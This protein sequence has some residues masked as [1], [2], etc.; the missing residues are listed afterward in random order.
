VSTR[1][2]AAP[3]KKYAAPLSILLLTNLLV[4]FR[5]ENFATTIVAGWANVMTHVCFTGGWL[6]GQLRCYEEVV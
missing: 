1:E 3:G 2:K 6:D 4:V 5:F